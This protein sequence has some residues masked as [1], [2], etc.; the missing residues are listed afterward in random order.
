MKS[1]RHRLEGID[2]CVLMRLRQSQAHAPDISADVEDRR[3]RRNEAAHEADLLAF[4]ADEN[5]FRTADLLLHIEENGDVLR[6]EHDAVLA[7]LDAPAIGI[8]LDE[9]LHLQERH[10]PLARQLPIEPLRHLPL[11]I[12]IIELFQ[13]HR[14]VSSHFFLVSHPCFSQT[15]TRA[16]TAPCRSARA[17]PAE[18]SRAAC[19]CTAR[20]RCA[21]S[22]SAR[23]ASPVLP[24]ASARTQSNR[25]R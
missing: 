17:F 6:P 3:P 16:S 20:S 13:F 14:I 19:P 22:I 2:S 23:S 18:S 10:E 12:Q 9:L 1:L 15:L 24:S 11:F 25:P 4:R 8:L 7:D 5:R 21:S